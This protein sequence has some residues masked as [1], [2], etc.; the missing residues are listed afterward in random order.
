MNI[1]MS[2]HRRRSAEKL[3]VVGLRLI[4]AAVFGAMGWGF[5]A[6]PWVADDLS[7]AGFTPGF[8]LILGVAHL[9]GGLALLVP[10]LAGAAA[11]GLGLCVAGTALYFQ[12]EGVLI[13]TEGPTVL[14]IVLALFVT[15]L[16][17]RQEVE[18]RIWQQMLARYADQQDAIPSN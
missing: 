16:R 3:A 8:G 15:C 1:D 17:L 10:R 2:N 18:T 6:S 12:S 9:A 4:L 13:G 5:L 7:R 11:I 14:V